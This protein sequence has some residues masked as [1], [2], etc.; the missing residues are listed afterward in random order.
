MLGND[1][2]VTGLVIE[3]EGLQETLRVDGV[4]IAIGHSPNT[5]VFDGQVKLDHGY[6]VTRYPGN[7]ALTATDVPGVFAAGDC[8]DSVYRQAITSAATGCQA[9]LDAQ[10]YL[11]EHS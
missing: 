11:E 1:S 5:A 8:A 6:I 7:R 2:G 10:R 9:A 3:G 4:F